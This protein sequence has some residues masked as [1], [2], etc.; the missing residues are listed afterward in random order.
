MIVAGTSYNAVR[1]DFGKPA[2]DTQGTLA[3]VADAAGP[4]GLG[5]VCTTAPASVSGHIALISRGVC[6]FSAKIRNLQAQGAVGAIVVNNQA[7]DPFVMSQ[8]GTADQATI[9]A[10]M[11]ART[12]RSALISAGNGAA[13]TLVAQSFYVFDA[14]KNDWMASFSSQGPTDVDFRVKPDVVA[15]GVNVLSSIPS[16]FCAAPPC[17]A[18]F[19]GTSM[20]TPHLAGSA[21]VVL[22]QRPWLSAAQ[23]RSAIVDTAD[24]SVLMNVSGGGLAT[25]VNTIGAGRENLLKAVGAVVAIDPVSV[26]FGAVPAGS[27]QTKTIAVALSNLSSVTSTFTS[28]E[29]DGDSAVGFSSGS[30][31]TLAPGA[32]GTIA[33]TMSASKDAPS[34]KDHQGTLT[35]RSNGAAVAHAAVYAFTK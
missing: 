7:T 2:T 13:S 12:D 32:S 21:A 6:S 31:V 14:S 29:S 24:Q 1:G 16:R 3:V 19:Q 5:T 25:D 34:G 17:F 11:V 26:S 35:I 23:T 10:Y 20:A 8:D 28:S 33:V 9:P 15:P 22:S 18:F 30:S 27:G 4:G